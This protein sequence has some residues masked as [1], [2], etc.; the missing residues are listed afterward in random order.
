[1]GYRRK[2]D[3]VSFFSLTQSRLSHA[4]YA[5]DYQDAARLKVAI[6]ALATNDTVGRAMSYLH[7]RKFLTLL[8]NIIPIFE[9]LNVDPFFY[10]FVA[11]LSYLEV[12]V[13]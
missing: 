5:E 13:S 9:N 2:T 12:F 4:V 8:Y 7:V 10:L 3:F 1:M 11:I 6:A